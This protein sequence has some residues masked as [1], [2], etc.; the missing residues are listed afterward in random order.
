MSFP[1]RL[2]ILPALFVAMHAYGASQRTFVSTT[3]V[4]NPS[5]FITAPCRDFAAAIAAT[6]PSGEVV[7]LDSGGYGPVTIGQAVSIIAPPGVYAGISVFAGTGITVAAAP[8]DKVTLRGL[9]INGQGGNTGV[10]ITSA[11]EVHVEQCIV[12]NLAADGIQVNGGTSVHIRNSLIRSNGGNGLAIAAGAPEVHAVD[13][14]FSRNGVHGILLRAGTLDAARIVADNNGSNGVRAQPVAAVNVVVTLSDSTLSGNQMT[15]AV[16]IPNVAGATARL[17]VARSTSARNT[18]GG[19]G[20]RSFNLG[21][22]FLTVADSASLE[23]NGNGVIVAD[24]NATGVVFN[25]T[26]A[27]NSGPDFDQNGTSIFRSSGNNALS[28]R[29]APDISGT[30]TPNPLK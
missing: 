1:S 5:C 18:G 15:G 27:R 20:I 12:S 4:N 6:T 7:V 17:A 24:S 26:I 8:T 9:T 2:V 10:V 22:A 11:G 30:I 16:A 25:S 21:T 28:G 29:G 13:S 23:N 3:G 19:Y 14:E